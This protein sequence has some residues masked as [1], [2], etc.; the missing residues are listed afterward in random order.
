M[1]ISECNLPTVTIIAVFGYDECNRLEVGVDTLPKH[2][3]LDKTTLE[4][5]INEVSAVIVSPRVS[6]I[7][8]CSPYA[9]NDVFNRFQEM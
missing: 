1:D 5:I 2:L 4:K 3:F 8:T 9:S 6:F 7:L